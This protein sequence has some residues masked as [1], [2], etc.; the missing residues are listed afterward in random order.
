MAMAFL[1]A[2]RSKDPNT[3][4]GWVDFAKL[5]MGRVPVYHC[6][7]ILVKTDTRFALLDIEPVS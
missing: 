7:F 6:Q 4:V 3:Q 1:T 5:Q 2:K